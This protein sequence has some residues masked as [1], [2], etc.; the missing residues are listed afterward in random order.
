MRTGPERPGPASAPKPAPG[1]AP[2]PAP[3]PAGRP[4]GRDPADTRREV[5]A[6]AAVVLGQRGFHGTSMAAVAQAAGLSHTG[7]LHHFPTKE[8]L[9]T[10]LLA[11]RDR[12]DREAIGADTGPPVGFAVLDRLRAVVVANTGRSTL[13]RLFTMVLGEAD[14]PDRSGDHPGHRWLAAHHAT[15]RAD[16]VQAIGRGVAAGTVRADAPAEAIA[17]LTIAVMDGLQVQWL[18]DPAHV[19]MVATY[20]T[21]AAGI[22]QQW[23]V[24]PD[25]ET[26]HGAAELS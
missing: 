17:R 11:E 13:V 26:S 23:E 6:S 2:G 22:R 4:P 14:D 7:L 15:A 8:T 20:D 9:L 18:Q 1:P 12:A 24:P 16:I 3:R 5:L 10:A 21:F 19:D 25:G